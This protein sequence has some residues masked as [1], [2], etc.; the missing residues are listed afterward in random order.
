VPGKNGC[1][2]FLIGGT[3]PYMVIEV[4]PGQEEEMRGMYVEHVFVHNFLYH[5]AGRVVEL[6]QELDGESMEEE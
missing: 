2:A 1:G 3:M 4:E 6:R 5:V